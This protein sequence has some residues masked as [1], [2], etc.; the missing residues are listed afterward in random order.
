MPDLII[1]PTNTSGNK[2]IIQDQAGGA[3]LTT[4]DSGAIL[5]S[6]VTGGSGLT[7]LGTV[8]SGTLGSAV[9]LN[10]DAQKNS[11]N[12]SR[13]VSVTY[14]GAVFDFNT[15]VFVGSNVSQSGGRITVTTAGLYLITCSVSRNNDTSTELDIILRIDGTGYGGT[16]QVVAGA[17]PPTYVAGSFACAV[18]LNASQVVDIYGSGNIYGASSV[19]SLSF[20]S[21]TRIGAIS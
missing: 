2:V 5:G 16:R 14:S 20:F 4:A 10:H 13:S 9:N 11:W 8:A 12:M 7:A 21:G 6:G 3:V 19:N 15:V 18:P 17:A 1:K